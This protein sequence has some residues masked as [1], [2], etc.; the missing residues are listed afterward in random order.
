MSPSMR[1]PVENETPNH[2]Q[3]PAEAS[4]VIRMCEEGLDRQ[5]DSFNNTEM[6]NFF[7]NDEDEDEEE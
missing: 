1:L 2:M 6:N 3:P 4:G 5:S 7:N